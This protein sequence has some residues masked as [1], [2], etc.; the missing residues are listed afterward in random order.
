MKYTIEDIKNV[1]TEQKVFKAKVIDKDK[2]VKILEFNSIIKEKCNDNFYVCL[3]VF[4]YIV[5]R[6]PIENIV[7]II[8]D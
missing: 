8:E 2:E 3:E 5:N 1:I 7:E 6:T 4:D